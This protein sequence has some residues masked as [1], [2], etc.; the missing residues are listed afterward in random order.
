MALIA[1][2]GITGNVGSRLARQLVAGEHQVRGIARNPDGFEGEGVDLVAADLTRKEEADRALQGADA[3]YLTLPEGGEDPLGLETAVADAVLA[4]AADQ[5][6]GHLVCHTALHADRGDTG[7]GILDNK[8]RVERE[9]AARGIPHTI[10]RPGWFMQNLYGALPYL[11][12]GMF[13][14]PWPADRPWAATSLGDIV[15]AAAAFL[16]REP[17]NGGFDL[18]VP[19]GITA[20]QICDAAGEARG[21]PVAYQAFDGPTRDFVDSYPLSEALK[22]LYAEL[23]DYFRTVDYRGDP[24]PVIR[25]LAGFSYSG[26]AEVVRTEILAG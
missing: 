4:A 11:Q 17:A 1:V 8:H 24:E 20:S 15:R 26:I 22:D 10:L 7:V 2:V 18:H 3:V 25:E 13:S 6:V 12:Q 21:E 5:D 19:G 9:L 16:E 14:M 23:F